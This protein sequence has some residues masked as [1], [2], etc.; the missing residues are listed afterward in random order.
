MHT[1]AYTT[2]N[3]CPVKFAPVHEESLP[4]EKLISNG[5]QDAGFFPDA[6]RY[7]HLDITCKRFFGECSAKRGSS[8]QRRSGMCGLTTAD[9]ARSRYFGETLFQIVA[10]EGRE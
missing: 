6:K 1:K 3:R 9:R 10:E 8:T 4:L 2:P 5:E 7:I